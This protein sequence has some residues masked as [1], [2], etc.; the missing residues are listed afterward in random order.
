MCDLSHCLETAHRPSHLCGFR[1]GCGTAHRQEWLCY[2]QSAFIK[3]ARKKS[4]FGGRGVLLHLFQI[5]LLDLLHHGFAAKQIFFELHR[6]L[7]RDDEKLV[8]NHF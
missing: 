5:A 1:H 8:L 7:A 3:N 4:S 6:N 2:R